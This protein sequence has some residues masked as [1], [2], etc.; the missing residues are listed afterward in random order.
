MVRLISRLSYK[1]SILIA[2][3]ITA[4]TGYAFVPPSEAPAGSPSEER[5]YPDTKA[6]SIEAEGRFQSFKQQHGE[7][8]TGVWNT[9]TGTSHRVVGQGLVIAESLSESNIKEVTE[10]FVRDNA[11]FLGVLPQS[12]HHV[13]TYNRGGRAHART[14]DRLSSADTLADAGPGCDDSCPRPDAAPV[15]F[16]L[17]NA[18]PNPSAGATTIAF[19]VPS[20]DAAVRI[21]VFDVMGRLTTTLANEAFD[22]GVHTVSWNGEDNRGRAVAPGLYFVRMQA[23]GFSGV[24]KVIKVK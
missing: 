5:M 7:G 23:G 6:P 18:L 22:P 2:V 15:A 8:W 13:S 11:S 9:D 19:A 20:P 10:E 3:L 17:F 12:L 4:S 14:K 24:T 16:A 21:E 1:S